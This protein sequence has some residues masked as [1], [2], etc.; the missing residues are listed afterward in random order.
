VEA[1]GNTAFSCSVRWRDVINPGHYRWTLIDRAVSPNTPIDTDGFISVTTCTVL[2]LSRAIHRPGSRS[3]G[4]SER[5]LVDI[6]MD[7]LKPALTWPGN[8]TWSFTS[9]RRTARL[10]TDRT[11]K[12]AAERLQNHPNNQSKRPAA[13]GVAGAGAAPP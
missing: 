10:N 2:L 11:A 6:D 12:K 4:P 9:R 13:A 8:T 3:T 7:Q 1:V 5:S